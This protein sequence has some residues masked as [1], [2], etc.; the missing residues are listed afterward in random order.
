MN[1]DFKT[2]L[3]FL[4][5]SMKFIP[6]WFF[7]ILLFVFTLLFFI[8]VSLIGLAFFGISYIYALLFNAGVMIITFNF[9]NVITA[10]IILYVA[11]V[12]FLTLKVLLEV[13]F[14]KRTK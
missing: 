13:M 1:D 8:K 4:N 10:G 5:K 2:S 7:R 11:Q 6:I 12:V 14:Y 3:I 9:V